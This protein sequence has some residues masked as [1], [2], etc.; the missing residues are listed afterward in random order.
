[1]RV[2]IIDHIGRFV[3]EGTIRN[4]RLERFGFDLPMREGVRTGDGGIFLA[5]PA[6]G[7]CS[8]DFDGDIMAPLWYGGTFPTKYLDFSL[9]SG[10]HKVWGCGN[11]FDTDCCVVHPDDLAKIMRNL[12]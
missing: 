10:L 8:V 12:V 3:A 2:R 6:L 7:Q 11:D 9:P 5:P 1:M 4:A